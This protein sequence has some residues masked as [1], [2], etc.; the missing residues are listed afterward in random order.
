MRRPR[1]L[2]VTAVAAERDAVLAGLDTS[3]GR[4]TSDATADVDV[5]VLA[6]G[7]GPAAAAAGA[8][9][10]LATAA[11]HGEP[12]AFA[13]SAGI[14]G[15]FGQPLAGT[16]LA[17]SIVAAD[18][19]ATTPDGFASVT[20]L[21]FGVTEHRPPPGLVRAV[22]E[23]AGAAIGPV[24]TVS[25]VTGTAER[26]RELAARHPGAVA[27]AMEGFGVAE[28]AAAH[29]VPVLELRTVSNAVGP[30]DRAAWR[31]PDALTALGTGCAA[32]VPVLRA[33]RA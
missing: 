17:S 30:R 19:G 13:V 8:A 7:V 23:A 4:D 18:L 9:T 27:E 11:A 16:V 29:G 26:A 10:A 24:L 33:W 32:T 20:E 28:A 3:D 22:A 1:I 2:I 15:G 12:F 21:G 31:I 6:A 25:T 5:D 14:A